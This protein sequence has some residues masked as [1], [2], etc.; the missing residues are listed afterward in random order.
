MEKGRKK[1]GKCYCNCCIHYSVHNEVLFF[2]AMG[3]FF[4]G[5]KFEFCWIS[6]WAHK[7]YKEIQRDTNKS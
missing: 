2:R 7:P 6:G 1:P 3:G 4:A 5:L